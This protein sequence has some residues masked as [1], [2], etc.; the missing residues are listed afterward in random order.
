M[1]A[2]ETNSTVG[3]FSGLRLSAHPAFTVMR[4]VR[5]RAC[6][7][8]PPVCLVSG[9]FLGVGLIMRIYLDRRCFGGRWRVRRRI[10]R[11][12]PVRLIYAVAVFRCRCAF[13][14]WR[15]LLATLLPGFGGVA[16]H[17]RPAGQGRA[18]GDK[19]ATVEIFVTGH[20]RL[21]SRR[22]S[23]MSLLRF[24]SMITTSRPASY[25]RAAHCSTERALASC[26]VQ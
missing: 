3:C 20:E 25:Q 23:F 18:V 9:E 8:R 4:A 13:A 26:N 10:R 15:S 16:L 14:S 17:N 24:S 1:A 21:P 7:V 6:R 12:K 22:E 19:M 5:R 11:L 2:A